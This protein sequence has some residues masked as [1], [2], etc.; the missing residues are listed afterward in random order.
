MHTCCTAVKAS[1]ASSK[2]GRRLC[3]IFFLAHSG[4][5]VMAGCPHWQTWKGSERLQVLAILTQDLP[6]SVHVSDTMTGNSSIHHNIAWP[7]GD[8]A[9]YRELT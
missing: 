6:A 9:W 3:Y 8:G 1:G 5:H 2:A 4:C 7:G